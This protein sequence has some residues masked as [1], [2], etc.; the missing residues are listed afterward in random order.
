M[1][2]LLPLNYYP[3]PFLR[4]K[5]KEIDQASIRTLQ[6]FIDDM[7]RTMKEKDGVGLAAPQVGQSIRLIVI[8]YK[9]GPFV[10]INPELS[11]FSFRK[12]ATEEGCL[13]IPGINGTVERYNKVK[14]RGLNRN[15]HVI[16]GVAEGF[17]ARILQHEVDHLD[18]ILFID[19]AKEITHGKLKKE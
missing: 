7:A 16:S 13:S 17:F 9:D 6:E 19:R 12:N 11:G 4:K 18:G 10:L 14:F 15:G 5:A 1:S 2:K 8:A 3:D